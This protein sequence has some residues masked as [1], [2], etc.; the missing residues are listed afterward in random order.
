MEAET[1]VS[2][3][4][5]DSGNQFDP[6][7]LRLSQNYA[8]AIGVKRARLTIP[9]RK[10][11]RQWF[12]RVHPDPEYMMDTLV[13]EL[14]EDREVYIVTPDIAGELPGEVTA[15]RLCT[16]INRQGVLFFWHIRLPGEDG[17][18]DAW[19]QAA[20]EQRPRGSSRQEMRTVLLAK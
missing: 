20:L 4:E 2:F 12:I 6:K 7:R 16:A 5:P 19:N 13:L 17:R 3:P 14:E 9:V 11:H 8:D 15:K 1:P 18:V 10:P